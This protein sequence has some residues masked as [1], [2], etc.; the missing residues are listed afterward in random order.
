MTRRNFQ[1]LIA[2]AAYPL[3]NLYAQDAQP[4]L[5]KVT[6][7]YQ[8]L[9]SYYFE[10][11]AVSE[12]TMKGHATKNELA[13]TVAFQAPDKFRLEFRYPSA[14]NWLR[15]S[16]GKFVRESRSLTKESKRTPVNRN[17][18][19]MLNGS[20]LYNFERLSKTANKP[21]IVRSEVIQVGGKPVDCSVVQFESHRRELREGETP[22]ISH[23]WVAKDTSLVLRE[24]IRISSI[25]KGE[26][27]EAKRTTTIEKMNVDSG[28]SSDLFSTAEG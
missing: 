25:V 7:A 23:V 8:A 20:P 13:F 22:G 9:N 27:S 28:V 24:E 15:V 21:T 11:K 14:G 19:Y 10:G 6:A 3:R 26:R 18:P 2:S 12:T 1:L 4:I 5:E 16:D 17:T